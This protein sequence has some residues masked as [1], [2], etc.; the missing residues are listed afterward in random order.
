MLLVDGG[1]AQTR[2]NDSA[3]RDGPLFSAHG[4]QLARR[5]RSFVPSRRA[6]LP[7]SL[8]FTLG[9]SHAFWHRDHRKLPPSFEPSEPSKPWQMPARCRRRATFPNSRQFSR[10]AS[11]NVRFV[12]RL[13]LVRARKS[14]PISRLR[15]A[16]RHVHAARSQARADPSTKPVVGTRRARRSP[17][18]N[19]VATAGARAGRISSRALVERELPTPRA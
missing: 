6:L 12:L 14:L 5:S 8:T 9:I 16:T 19:L 2:T 13:L 17:P 7:F 1:V 18:L 4:P 10:P 3:V 11:R 15:T